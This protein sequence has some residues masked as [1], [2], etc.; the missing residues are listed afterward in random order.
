MA[1]KTLTEL[2]ADLGTFQQ[3]LQTAYANIPDIKD[4]DGN[5]IT[6]LDFPG[7]LGTLKSSMQKISDSLSAT[8]SLKAVA[9]PTTMAS[10]GS[11]GEFY[12]EASPTP[13]LYLCVAANTWVRFQ[14]GGSW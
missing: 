7:A 9:K 8:S 11:I 1:D 10:P 12:F 5:A 14:T 2:I 6:P 13:F 3:K 4:G